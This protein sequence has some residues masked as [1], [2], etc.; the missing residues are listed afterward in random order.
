MYEKTTHKILVRVVPEYLTEESDVV[1][2]I[3]FWAYH[4]TIE[5]QS[6]QRIRLRRRHWRIVDEHGHCRTVDGEGVVGEC[7]TLDPGVRFSYS[8]SVSLPTP[9]G[10]MSGA[11][12]M[13][14]EEGEDSQDLRIDIPLFLLESPHAFRTVH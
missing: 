10:E 7:P 14:I 2:D 1:R 12:D 8:S 11:Y 5:N 9:S 6:S 4:I 13:T 3:Y